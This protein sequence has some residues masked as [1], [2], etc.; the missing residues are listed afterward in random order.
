[1]T[2]SMP[3]GPPTGGGM[4]ERGDLLA[5]WAAGRRRRTGEAAVEGL[6]FAFYW[7][8]S[9]EDHQDPAT[10]RQWQLDRA[11]PTISGA[12]RIVTEYSDIG[13]TRALSWEMRV[14][15]LKLGHRL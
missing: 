3:S 6:R 8:V 14:V 2:T 7:R 4:P 1:M 13:L 12:G 15:L 5:G 9:T 10:S 11:V